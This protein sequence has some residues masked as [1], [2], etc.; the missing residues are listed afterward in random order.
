MKPDIENID[1]EWLFK[2]TGDPFVD[3]G[4]Y[5]LEEFSHYYPDANLMDLIEKAAAI[6]VDGWDSRINK[7]FHNSKITN[8]SIKSENKV[9]ECVKY[10]F[11]IITDENATLGHCRITGRKCLVF[12]A[13]RENFVLA[14]AGTLSNFNHF[15]DIGLMVSK[16]ALIRVFFLPL[17]CKLLKERVT[18][19][20]SNNPTVS[21]FFARTICAQNIRNYVQKVSAS[22]LTSRYEAN[23]SAFFHFIDE[24]IL[25]QKVNGDSEKNNTLTMFS[26][27]NAGQN[28]NVNILQLPFEAFK[29]YRVAVNAVYKASWSHFVS[30]YYYPSFKGIIDYSFVKGKYEVEGRKSKRFVERSEYMYWGNRIY[31]KLLENDSIVSDILK[32]EEKNYIDFDEEN[33]LNIN[34]IKL[35]LKRIRK[36]KEE[37]IHKIEQIADFIISSNDVVFIKNCV[38][39]LNEAQT[40]YMLSRF[41]VK[42]IVEINYN[43]E[44][45]NTIITVNDYVNY[46]FSDDSSWK[47][48]RNVLL[49]AIYERLH[50]SK[51]NI[52]KLK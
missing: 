43:D 50:Q 10:Y 28:P 25:Q 5:A 49:I 40:T 36:M 44:N 17:G 6:Y 34:L 15:L 1:Y 33:Y 14:G 37:T 29:F 23:A 16:E 26:F 18:L 41:L 7:I 39:K 21:S 52:N 2:P 4:G 13:R 48:I 20:T 27:S 8:S 3:A 30:Q 46:L 35:Y 51:I 24:L 31:Q 12:P 47:E 45:E 11:S 38:N 32:Y 9:R 42:N 22:M 19:I